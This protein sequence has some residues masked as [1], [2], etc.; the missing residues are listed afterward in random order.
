MY[1]I[2]SARLP[3]M[4]G[5][6][7]LRQTSRLRRHTWMNRTLNPGNASSFE[8]M[9]SFR[10][11]LVAQ[12]AAGQLEEHILEVRRAMEVAQVFAPVEIV[13]QSVRVVRIAENR[14]A[15][16]LAALGGS[17]ADLGSP[18][19]RIFPIDLH[20]LRFDVPLDQRARGAF[21]DD[22]AMIHDGETMAEALRLVHEM[23][24]QEYR[25]ALIEQ[26]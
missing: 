4:D 21:G 9:S 2:G 18:I 23:G 1:N 12:L 17:S 15:G 6:A 19:F 3:S 7:S 11:E 20:D 25:L 8:F 13:H 5:T 16:A 14:L 22:A 26:L 24:C 10:A